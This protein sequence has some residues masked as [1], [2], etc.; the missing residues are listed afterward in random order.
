MIVNPLRVNKA[1]TNEL[2]KQSVFAHIAKQISA[3]SSKK[4]TRDERDEQRQ[5]P[6]PSGR[7][8]SS[9]QATEMKKRC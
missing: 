3:E 6:T 8:M 2:E 5:G 7:C 1:C 4:A 9:E